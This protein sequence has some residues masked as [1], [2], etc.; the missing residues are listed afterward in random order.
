VTEEGPHGDGDGDAPTDAERDARLAALL[1]V[2][3]G[4]PARSRAATTPDPD[5]TFRAFAAPAPPVDPVPS[6]EAPG[7]PSV[8]EPV[9]VEEPPA[10]A[11]VAVGGTPEADEPSTRRGGRDVRTVLSFAVLA[12]L[13]LAGAGLT[14]AGSRIVRSSTQGEVVS[15]GA[16]PGEPGYEALV[17][18][19]PTFALFHEVD[20]LVDSITV[21]TLPDPDGAGGGVILVPTRTVV[22]MPLFDVAPVEVAY[23]L[24]DDRFGAEALGLLLTTAIEARTI[25][26]DQRW[27]DLVTPV[28]PLTVDNPNEL[29]VD[30]EVRFPIG[31]IQLGAADV[32]PYLSARIE[33][34]SDL[35]RLFRHQLFWEAWL[36][37]V[38]AAG[39]PEAVPG[40]LDTGIG[41]FVRT[42]GSGDAVIEAL[43]VDPALPDSYG[44]EPAF[45]PDADA[46]EDLVFRLVPFPVSPAPGYRA[47]VRVLNGTDDTT[48]AAAVAS[49]LTPVGVEIVLVGNALSLDEEQTTVRY[50]GAEFRD[51]AEAIVDLL[52]VGRVREETRP[53]DAVDIT[54]TLGADHE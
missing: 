34:E 45:L 27:A 24:A 19:T 20:G 43:P 29:V 39:T 13:L 3:I 33:G 47:R 11:L 12:V 1:S 23:D 31:E 37:A 28:A 25:V 17:E 4:L 18:A 30:D 40:E 41:R 42:L 22:E 15:Q 51:E 5:E 16:E 48:Q 44:P 32:G 54:V 36:E 14:Y 26:D 21:L 2:D 6:V 7:A 49:D 53:S 10:E 46:L 35:A 9:P 52:G 38:A 50:F 8:P